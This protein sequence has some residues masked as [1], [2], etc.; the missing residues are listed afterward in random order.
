MYW[1]DT[2]SVNNEHWTPDGHV[3]LRLSC[4]PGWY[5]PHNATLKICLPPKES[6]TSYWLML[7]Y[8]KHLVDDRF[9]PTGLRRLSREEYPDLLED[10]HPMVRESSR[11]VKGPLKMTS[12]QIFHMDDMPVD[13]V[14]GDIFENRCPVEI[15]NLKGTSYVEPQFKPKMGVLSIYLG[16][17]PAKSTFADVKK[18]L[19]DMTVEWHVKPINGAK[20]ERP[21][22]V[23][24]CQLESPCLQAS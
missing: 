1:R 7:V 14:T 11:K 8:R 13:H 16:L 19:V 15:F 22:L 12:S 24:A 21:S 5:S 17:K 20:L 18:V 23:R 10:D 6:R 4:H 3:H 9:A 2:I